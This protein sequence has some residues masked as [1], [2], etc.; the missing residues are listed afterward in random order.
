M[1]NID[2][3]FDVSLIVYSAD[4]A[5]EKLLKDFGL[6]TTENSYDKGSMR[7]NRVAGNSAWRKFSK[8]GEEATLSEHFSQVLSGME[9]SILVK[10]EKVLFGYNA[11]I[12]IAVYFNSDVIAV[13]SVYIP[14][15]MLSWASVRNI[16]IGVTMYPCGEGDE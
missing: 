14:V 9:N 15:E 1:G 12:E 3:W 7:G 10:E 6:I 5:L 4:V 13:P 11:Q 8:L 16:E 2:K